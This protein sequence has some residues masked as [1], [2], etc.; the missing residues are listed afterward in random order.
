MSQLRDWLRVQ[1]RNH[2]C[3]CFAAGLLAIVAIAPGGALAQQAPQAELVVDLVGI[4]DFHA[5]QLSPDGTEV[6]DCDGYYAREWDL[7]SGHKSESL[8]VGGACF[9]GPAGAGLD[10]A[11]PKSLRDRRGNAPGYLGVAG[12]R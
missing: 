10:G 8:Q 9:Y 3:G 1:I 12:I 11:S 2:R 6:A 5:P 7:A 4:G